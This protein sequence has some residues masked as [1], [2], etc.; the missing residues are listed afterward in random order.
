MGTTFGAVTQPLVPWPAPPAQSGQSRSEGRSTAVLRGAVAGFA[1]A[2]ALTALAAA[3]R[4]SEG[5]LLI[6]P[7]DLP[8]LLA[9]SIGGGCFGP[10]AARARTDSAWLKVVIGLALV[11]VLVGAIATGVLTG[12][13]SID[14]QATFAEATFRIIGW[15]AMFGMLAVAGFG[16]LALPST[17]LASTFWA[18]LVAAWRRHDA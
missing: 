14:Q 3:N 11:A 16:A 12:I 1:V 17:L 2:M 15:G 13:Q 8:T 10:S 6:G 5:H 7:S 4:L 9:G 18:L